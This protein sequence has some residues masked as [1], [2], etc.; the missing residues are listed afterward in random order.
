M[1]GYSGVKPTLRCVL[2]IIKSHLSN[3]LGISLYSPSIPRKCQ[4][5]LT[6]KVCLGGD[7]ASAP[8]KDGQRSNAVLVDIIIKILIMGK[9]DF[10]AK[11]FCFLR[12]ELCILRSDHIE[13]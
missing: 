4:P 6:V 7:E 12:R 2:N 5:S 11:V 3:K 8:R 13:Q 10:C 1:A 9:L